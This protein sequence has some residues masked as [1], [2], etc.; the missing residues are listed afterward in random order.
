MEEIKFSSFSFNKRLKSMLKVDV[1]RMFKMSFYYIMVGISFVIPI[2]VLVMTTLM[3]G[4]ESIDPVTNEVVVMEQIFTN[5]WQAIGS[6]SG[7]TSTNEAMGEMNMAAMC[8]IDMLIFAV[9][10][11]ICVFVGQDF[12][13]GYSKNL[14]TV[15]SSKVDYVISKTIVGVIGGA[16]MLIAYF[17]GAI[18]G[19][20]I[21]SLSFEMVGFTSV[22]L[23]MCMLSKI[24]LL[25]V[26]VPIF[27]V[28]SVVGKGRV[29]LSM[30]LTFAVSMLLFMMV[31][32]LSPLN[33]TI[34]NVLVTLLL[35]ALFSIGIGAISNLVLK[36]TSLV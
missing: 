15:R 35:G 36:K 27:L 2:L 25:F 8:N 33:A 3:A 5:V 30:I 1:Q 31:A 13:S 26:F 19:G 20:A 9:A 21:S 18:V 6:I 12:R 28:M 16:S 24:G 11:L 34:V 14:F 4:T 7:G 10:V 29:W 17:I 32:M 23:I 22:N